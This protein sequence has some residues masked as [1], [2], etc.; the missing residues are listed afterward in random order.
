MQHD[1]EAVQLTRAA[2]DFQEW[3]QTSELLKLTGIVYLLRVPILLFLIAAFMTVGGLTPNGPGAAILEGI[4]DVAWPPS[5]PGFVPELTTV[6][7]F[8]LLTLSALMFGSTL[9]VCT[10]N[11][12]RCI[13]RFNIQIGD[14]DTPAFRGIRLLYTIPPV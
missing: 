13:E 7:R 5:S 14:E 4:Y 9:A 10:R 12:L 2:F 3:F 6:L 11:I 8:L 1:V